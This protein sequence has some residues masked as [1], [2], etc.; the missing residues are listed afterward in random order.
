[1]DLLDR[2]RGM[3]PW[4]VDIRRDLHRHPELSFQEVRTAGVAV[5]ELTSLGYGVRQGIA[6]T[7]VVAEL[8]NGPGPTV[9]IRADMD[10]LPI[11]EDTAL[12]FSSTVPGVMH[13]CGHDCHTAG[14]LGTARILAQLQEE[15]TLP[16]GRIRLLFQPSE[17]SS[18]DEGKSGAMRMVEEGAMEGVD[19]V[20]GLHVGAHLT[21]G[22][23]FLREGPFWGGSDE[24]VVTVHGKGAHAARPHEGI[25]ALAL[26]AL[27]VVA[28]QQVVSRMT[29]PSEPAVLSFGTIRGGTAPNVVCERVTLTGSLRY[30]DEAVRQRIHEGVR[31]AFG[32]AERMGARVEVEFR[33]G[34]PPVVNDPK[35][36]RWIEEAV[37]PIVGE[38]G[39]VRAEPSL[40]AEDF[41][42]LARAAPGAFFWLGAAIDDPR[43]H[44]SPRF[45][46]DEAV[47]P[48][49]AALLA[50]SAIHLL[51]RLAAEG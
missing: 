38:G 3:A 18:D 39:F 1:M 35:V 40:L 50:A 49:G 33:G 25:D 4:L 45:I 8:E 31:R 42:F 46:V 26:A 12:P 22:Q 15:G 7:G 44:H 21:A 9:A 37:R 48:L 5:A 29:G 27:G 28:A 51:E 2:A 20:I 13:A 16:A 30:F 14:L 36:S 41:A 34:Y 43:E 32:T 19:A 23:V 11:Q 47:L 24:V 10:A 6:R 17:E